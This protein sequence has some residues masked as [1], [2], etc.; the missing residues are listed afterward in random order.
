VQL[1]PERQKIVAMIKGCSTPF[2]AESSKETLLGSI[3]AFGYPGRLNSFESL[4]L[5]SSIFIL[6]G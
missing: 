5:Y 4:V 1:F 3:K 2:I 6:L